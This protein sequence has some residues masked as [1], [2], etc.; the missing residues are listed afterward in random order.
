M[1]MRISEGFEGGA[2]M[3]RPSWRSFTETVAG[4]VERLSQIG[5]IP[6]GLGEQAV[7]HICE[8]EAMASTAMVDIGVSI[9]HARIDGVKG[10]VAALAVSPSAVYQVA[11]GL[12]ITIVALVMSSPSLTGEHLNFLS[13]ISMLLQSDLTRQRLRNA[14]DSDEVVRLVRENESLRG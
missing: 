13:S 2:V 4:L 8:R 6:P 14:S 10:V 12:P 5:K 11:D 9:P 3:V 7:R 1:A